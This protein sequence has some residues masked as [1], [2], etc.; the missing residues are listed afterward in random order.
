MPVA[1]VF[2][3]RPPS[4]NPL[5]PI[6]ALHAPW[7]LNISRPHRCCSRNSC[8]EPAYPAIERGA[9]PC[10]IFPP[11]QT[12]THAPFALCP[13]P[14]H[15]TENIPNTQHPFSQRMRRSLLRISTKQDC[16]WQLMELGMPRLPCGTVCLSVC[17]SKATSMILSWLMT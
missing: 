13:V 2:H 4:M 8:N 1:Y 12:H 15:L 14:L 17:L 16:C 6:H 3:L 11:L 5:L 7:C 9:G 10:Q